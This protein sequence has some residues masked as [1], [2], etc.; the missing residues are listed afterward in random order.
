MITASS[1]SLHFLGKIIDKAIADTSMGWLKKLFFF[2]KTYETQLANVIYKTIAEFEKTK[3]AVKGIPYPFYHSEILFEKLTRYLLFKEENYS[4]KQEDFEANQH[5][6]RP[7]QHEIR[8]FFTLFVK[9][10]EQD[11]K[12][13]KLFISE[14]YQQ[15]IYNQSDLLRTVLGQNEKVQKQLDEM[16]EL[17]NQ[18]LENRFS[19]GPTVSDK[20]LP[21]GLS[22]HSGILRPAKR[23]AT[24]D[25]VEDLLKK[26]KW[27]SLLG[28]ISTGKT[29]LAVLIGKK[30]PNFLWIDLRNIEAN[31]VKRVILEELATEYT[32]EQEA[33]DM[34]LVI[35]RLPVGSLIV[36]DDMPKLLLSNRESGQLSVLISMICEKNYILS[37]SNFPMPRTFSAIHEQYLEFEIPF[38]TNEEIIE[39]LQAYQAPESDQEVIAPLIKKLS[40]GHPTIV[41]L[42]CRYLLEKKWKIDEHSLMELFGNNYAV[43]FDNEINEK[44]IGTVSEVTARELLYRMKLIYGNIGDIEVAI[45]AG[46]KPAINLPHEKLGKLDGLWLQKTKKGYE[47]SPLVKRLKSNLA[48]SLIKSI[49][50]NL[51]EHMVSGGKLN[52]VQAYKAIIYF[53]S[54]GEINR[55]GQLLIIVLNAAQKNSSLYFDW[56]FETFWTTVPLPTNMD[57]YL[58]MM[59]RFLQINLFKASGKDIGFLIMDLEGIIS[60]AT[61]EKVNSAPATFQLTMFYSDRDATKANQYLAQTISQMEVLKQEKWLDDFMDLNLNI[62]VLIW[63][64]LLGVK[65]IEDFNSWFEMLKQFGDAQWK[66]S[67]EGDLHYVTSMIAMSRLFETEEGKSDAQW[68]AL[69]ASYDQIIS[70]LEGYGNIF[71][72]PFAFKYKIRSQLRMNKN[73]MEAKITFDQA[74]K[75]FLLFEQGLFIVRDE[76]GRELLA[77]GEKEMALPVLLSALEVQGPPLST[78]RVYTNL[79]ISEILLPNDPKKALEFAKDAFELQ[80]DNKFIDDVSSAKIIAEYSTVQWNAGLKRETFYTI[81]EGLEKILKTYRAESDYKALIIRLGHSINYYFHI[82]TGLPHPKTGGEDY[83]VPFAGMYFRSTEAL[84]EGGFYFDTRKFMQAYLMTSCFEALNDRER[85]RDWMKLTMQFDREDIDNPFRKILMNSNAYAVLEG[86]YVNAIDAGRSLMDEFKKEPDLTKLSPILRNLLSDPKRPKAVLDNSYDI[87]LFEYIF[88]FIIVHALHRYIVSQ[89]KQVL[90]DLL[91]Q[92]KPISEY[93]Q[94]PHILDFAKNAINYLLD[95]GMTDSDINNIDTFDGDDYRSQRM[96]LYLIASCK[97]EALGALKYQF[98]LI[99]RLENY[100]GKVTGTANLRFIVIPFFIDFWSNRTDTEPESFREYAFL[101]NKGWEDIK[102]APPLD[103]LRKLFTV[104]AYHLNY[105][106]GQQEQNWLDGEMK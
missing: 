69:I 36:F 23:R 92:L 30:Y 55:A 1:I 67:M 25:V 16:N 89:D 60:D 93:F 31:Q 56:S 27:V 12:L 40:I 5:I 76:F 64:N 13:K 94:T 77:M 68:P 61:R 52:Q 71:L 84:L 99:G 44:L 24:V 42:M 80:K 66:E 73:P 63:N 54:A 75:K 74:E 20:Y 19:V 46:P 22:P 90:Q 49:N 4:P 47:L 51:G 85:A 45:V 105:E 28:N 70:M 106:P 38:L 29:Q 43:D 3:P 104:L 53:I 34:K 100:A 87:Y 57:T 2:S 39:V 8:D 11:K 15:E 96:L 37:T 41:S 35:D 83:V 14:S 26:H 95:D 86:N 98:A 59:I 103:Q 91:E 10:V 18:G 81:A 9:N 97:V 32:Q 72:L 78:D 88:N 21:Q 48:P 82:F 79:S 33:I 101:K 58:R 17:I 62:D 65:N 50:Y 102:N 6:K 7:T